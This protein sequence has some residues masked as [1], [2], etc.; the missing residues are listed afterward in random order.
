MIK[1]LQLASTSNKHPPH[2]PHPNQTT[3]HV[4]TGPP[5]QLPMNPSAHQA[6]RRI[7]RPQSLQCRLRIRRLHQVQNIQYWKSR[8]PNVFRDRSQTWD[9][10]PEVERRDSGA[11]RP[12]SYPQPR[13]SS[14]DERTTEPASDLPRNTLFELPTPEERRFDRARSRRFDYEGEFEEMHDPQANIP[15]IP[16]DMDRK[17]VRPPPRAD[18]R[19]RD[20]VLVPPRISLR[21][22][23]SRV[24]KSSEFIFG[25]SVVEAAITAQ[26]RKIYRFYVYAGAGRTIQSWEKGNELKKLARKLHPGIEIIDEPDIGNMDSMADSRP[27]K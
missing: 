26:R 3:T 6:V 18:R 21:R 11:H 23:I 7:L 9:E 16:Y 27:H 22:K 12:D 24:A 13:E 17:G 20:D 4:L 8:S 25:S 10:Q 2:P 15:P 14:Q 1:Q 5:S 19:E